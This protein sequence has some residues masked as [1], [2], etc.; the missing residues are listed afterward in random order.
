MSGD[1]HSVGPVAGRGYRAR[2]THVARSTG[3]VVILQSRPSA[4]GGNLCKRRSEPLA[5]LASEWHSPTI[6]FILYKVSETNPHK[7]S[8]ARTEYLTRLKSEAEIKLPNTC[9]AFGHVSCYAI[10]GGG[11]VVLDNYAVFNKA[12]P[13][14]LWQHWWWK[15]PGYK[16]LEER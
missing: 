6:R 14:S 1:L 4:T 15:P 5:C 3:Q 8:A 7:S 13:I 2:P 16:L 11:R 12:R 9:C 10:D